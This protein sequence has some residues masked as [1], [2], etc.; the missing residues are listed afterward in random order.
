[1]TNMIDWRELFCLGIVEVV[2]LGIISFF[3]R[4]E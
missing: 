3:V 1:M 2:V 4:G